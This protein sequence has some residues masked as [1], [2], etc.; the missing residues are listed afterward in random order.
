MAMASNMMG[1]EV[2]WMVHTVAQNESTQLAWETGKSTPEV[3]MQVQEHSTR[4]THIIQG[5]SQETCQGCR[6]TTLSW[7]IE[8]EV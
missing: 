3:H 4:A 7:V 6:S 5:T 8:N 1:E 2:G